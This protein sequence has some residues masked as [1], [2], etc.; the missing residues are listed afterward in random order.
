MHVGEAHVATAEA[1]GESFM[2]KAELVQDRGVDIVDVDRLFDG[3][4]PH[5]VGRAESY[6]T[7][8]AAAGHPNSIATDVMITSVVA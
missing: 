5:F 7:S 2:I 6:T 1:E 4:H 8:D 3:T